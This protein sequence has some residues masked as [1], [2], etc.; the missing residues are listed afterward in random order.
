M[1]P[2]VIC[3]VLALSLPA[4]AADP[5]ATEL[6]AKVDGALNAFKDGIFESKLRLT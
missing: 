3:T 6:L 2:L 1:K 4:A 5:S